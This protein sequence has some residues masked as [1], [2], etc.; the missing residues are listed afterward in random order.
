MR[1]LLMQVINYAQGMW[2]FRWY[3]LFLAWIVAT[4]GWAWAYSLPNQYRADARVYVDTESVLRPLLRGLAIESDVR[5]RVA[6]MTRTLLTRPT[7]EKVA[8]KTDLDLRAQTPA[9]M[10]A[11]LE[12]LQRTIGISSDGRRADLYTI[13][14]TDKNPAAAQ[15]VVQTLLDTLVEQTLGS[16]RT[17]TAVAQ[18]FLDE[19]IGEYERR[20]TAAEERLADFKRKHIGMMPSE[21]KGYYARLQAASDEIEQ[22][23]TQVSV[24]ENRRD[25]LRK[26]LHAEEG[27]LAPTGPTDIETKIKERQKELDALLLRYTDQHPDVRVLRETIAQL[28]ARAKA[29]QAVAK[30]DRERG[31]ELNPVY[32]AVKIEL[33]KA[34]VELAALRTQLADRQRKAEQLR[35]MV[36]TIPEVEAE[37]ARLNRDYS[38]TKGQ[39]DS[40]VE[41]KESARLSQQ[42]EQKSDDIKFRIVEPPV[43]PQ[44]P[45]GPNRLRYVSV[46]LLAGLGAGLGFAFLL[47]ELRPVFLNTRTLREITGLPVLGSVS[48]KL[49]P[50]QRMK[51]R[52]ELVSFVLVALSLLAAYGGALMLQEKGVRLAQA[53]LRLV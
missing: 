38:I 39:Y 43:L 33:G 9:Q 51:L 32:Q 3:A 53:L 7:L 36:N 17:D 37:L 18:R 31:L 48:L 4:A 15:L 10:E 49:L 47:N 11:L 8:R 24:A 29:E 40:L 30:T 50:K 13:S 20:L 25:E 41:R 14:Y 42:A 28:K 52:M 21:G 2:R 6:V 35:R 26:Q 5:S 12:R 44:K 27:N 19:Q 1:E 16:S 34:E 22:I 45:S 46:M 23:R